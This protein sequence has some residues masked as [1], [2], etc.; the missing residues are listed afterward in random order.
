[1]ATISAVIRWADNTEELKR[2]LK[3]GVEQIERV[4][5]SAA[6]LTREMKPRRRK[7]RERNNKKTR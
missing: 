5:Q 3:E 7:K 2:N 6:K 1:M 4:K